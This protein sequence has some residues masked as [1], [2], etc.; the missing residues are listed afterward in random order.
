M[1]YTNKDIR[2]TCV[3]LYTNQDK[4]ITIEIPNLQQSKLS[5]GHIY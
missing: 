2:G 1:L 4:R 3:I 5:E